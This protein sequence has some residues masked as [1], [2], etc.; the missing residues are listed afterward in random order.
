MA[1][2]AAMKKVLSPSSDTRIT[3][4]AAT[5]PWINPGS[6]TDGLSRAPSWL[7]T[8]PFCQQKSNYKE[9]VLKFLF[10]LAENNQLR[11]KQKLLTRGGIGDVVLILSLLS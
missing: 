9:K 11:L 3:E 4:M 5:N 1:I 8:P 10:Y 6:A 7:I 2:M